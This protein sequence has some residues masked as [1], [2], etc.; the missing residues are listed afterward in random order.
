MVN[1]VNILESDKLKSWKPR[2]KY[3]IGAAL[4]ILLIIAV[5]LVVVLKKS[6]EEPKSKSPNGT[7]DD[8]IFAHTVCRHGARNSYKPYPNDR[9]RSEEL[10]W[11]E[12]Y[13]Q[14]TKIGK[15]QHYALGKYLR[16]R[17]AKLLGNG[18]YAADKVL[19]YSTVRYTNQLS[20]ATTSTEC[21]GI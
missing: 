20:A 3:F 10:Y 13:A 19:V 17:Y 14:L 9:W 18:D 4:L 1:K 15:Q 21:D 6:P 5:V 16:E 7:D 12:G 8:L 11:P 2:L